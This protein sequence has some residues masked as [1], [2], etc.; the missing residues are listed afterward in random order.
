MAEIAARG[1]VAC[2]IMATAKFDQYIGG[3]YSE[4]HLFNEGNHIIS[5]HGW[6]V[7]ENG[8]EYWI[9]RN[10]WGE[11]WERKA[12]LR[13]LQ[14]STKMVKVTTTILV[15]KEIVLGLSLLFQKAGG[16]EY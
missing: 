9:G 12:G 7:D 10:S 11:P 15:S 2:E 1:P 13:L 16:S 6:G 5:L 4:Y 14:V 8:I 3:T